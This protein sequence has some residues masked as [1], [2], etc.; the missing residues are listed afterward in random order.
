MRE[1]REILQGLA[2]E[3]CYPTRWRCTGSVEVMGS[4]CCCV[5]FLYYYCYFSRLKFH[6]HFDITAAMIN[7]V[8]K[9]FSAVQIYQDLLDIYLYALHHLWV[10]YDFK[11]CPAPS[12]QDGSVGRALYRYRRDFF[13]F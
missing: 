8:F 1:T 6:I 5:I 2:S 9:S 13:K 10:S 3:S 4:S 11:T 7:H 12:W